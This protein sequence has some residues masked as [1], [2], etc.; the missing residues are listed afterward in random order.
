MVDVLGGFVIFT[1]VIYVLSILVFF[2]RKPDFT[3]IAT[4]IAVASLTV[5]LSRNYVWGI[6]QGMM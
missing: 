1:V 6:V 5:Y 2:K 3:G 4:G